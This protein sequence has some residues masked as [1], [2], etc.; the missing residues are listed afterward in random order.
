MP[1]YAPSPGVYLS[2]GLF[3]KTEG[4]GFAYVNIHTQKLEFYLKRI[5][6]VPRFLGFIEGVLCW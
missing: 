4:L 6:S 2:K 5:V 3:R 1:G